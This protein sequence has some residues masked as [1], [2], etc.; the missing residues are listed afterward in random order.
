MIAL[1]AV[2]FQRTVFLADQVAVRRTEGLLKGF[3]AQRT[4]EGKGHAMTQTA[5]GIS[6]LSL[7]DR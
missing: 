7:I 6:E 4:L 1:V 5:E 3:L 2:L